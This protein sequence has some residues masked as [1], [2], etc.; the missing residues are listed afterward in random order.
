MRHVLSVTILLSGI[1]ASAQ[2][3]YFRFVYVPGA[4]NSGGDNKQGAPAGGKG[5]FP[6]Q[7]GAFPGQPGAQQGQPGAMQAKGKG[8]GVPG[9]PEPGEDVNVEDEIDLTNARHIVIEVKS[10][11]KALTLPQFNFQTVWIEHKWGRTALQK[12]DE[13]HFFRV[14]ENRRP[15]PTVFERYTARR[16][17]QI[18]DKETPSAEKLLDVA[19]YALTHG[20]ME[21]FHQDMAE[22]VKSK[23]DHKVAVLYSKYQAELKRAPKKADMGV[24]WKE[25]LGGNFK[26]TSSDH[27]VALYDMQTNEPIEVKNRLRQMEQN[28]QSFYY[29]FALRGKYLPMPDRRQVVVMVDKPD[30]FHN[31]HQAFDL[32]PLASD[33]FYSSRENL[34]VLS[35]TSLDE[36]YDALSKASN[37]MWVNQGWNKETL[38]KGAWKNNEQPSAVATAQET[39]LLLRALQEE[40]ELATVTHIGSRQLVAASGLIPHNVAAPDWIQFGLGSFFETPKGAYWP[41][42][43]APHWKYLVNFKLIRDTK[44]P[45]SD[46]ELRQVVTDTY[47]RAARETRDPVA[48]QKAQTM[49]W[50]LT[51]YL[52]QQ[53]QLEGLYRFFD[54]VANLPRDLQYDSDV[55]LSCFARSFGLDDA[56][57]PDG[58]NAARFR[59]FAREWFNFMNGVQLE[60]SD[61]YEVAR[62]TEEYRLRKEAEAKN[63]NSVAG[64]NG[65]PG[66]FGQ[67]G[68]GQPGAVQPQPGVQGARPANR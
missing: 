15:V 26:I 20:M 47:F 23:P 17:D 10:K 9:Q 52:T 51:Y 65:Q 19:E 30:E 2:A 25:R 36:A 63:A 37:D 27:Y 35:N 28:F 67:P 50:A 49:S 1:V 48:L 39:A 54:E 4:G 68:R 8:K 11:F 58:V 3:E 12:T 18:K 24:T 22:L 53:N 62:K 60:V 46:D 33:G 32:Q 43:A 42:T 14:M 31:L 5:V 55:Y 13:F 6:G 45:K 64:P 56:N 21:R 57:T 61:P 38:L 16:K 41:G 66:A 40:S 29:W 34:A 44:K 59:G 7:P